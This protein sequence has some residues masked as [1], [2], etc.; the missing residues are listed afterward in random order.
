MFSRMYL[1]RCMG[2]VDD[3]ITELL[4]LCLDSPQFGPFS[5]KSSVVHFNDMRFQAHPL[6]SVVS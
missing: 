1:S 2:E 6:P 5:T 3:L 4:A